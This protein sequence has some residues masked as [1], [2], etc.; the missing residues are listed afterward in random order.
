MVVMA[1]MVMA[2]VMVVIA[3]MA[4]MLVVMAGMLVVMVVIAPSI[5]LRR[6]QYFVIRTI[7]GARR[8]PRMQTEEALC[9]RG[10]AQVL[11]IGM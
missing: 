8:T 9:L 1:V 11:V 3:V 4:G 5:G 2:V 6:R 10:M 7:V